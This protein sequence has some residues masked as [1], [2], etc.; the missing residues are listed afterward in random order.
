[1]GKNIHSLQCSMINPPL[2]LNTQ[3]QVCLLDICKSFYLS[4]R[5]QTLCYL[6]VSL[7][8]GPFSLQIYFSSCINLLSTLHIQTHTHTPGFSVIFKHSLH[9]FILPIHHFCLMPL[10]YH[11]LICRTH[12][13]FSR[14]VYTLPV[15]QKLFNIQYHCQ[16]Q[17]TFDEL[18]F[19]APSFPWL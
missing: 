5:I 12:T 11:S 7:I 4:N 16:E 8:F 10:L 17:L 14:L 15:L 9:F 2:P 1:M 19:S 18:K 6:M 13:R 3:T